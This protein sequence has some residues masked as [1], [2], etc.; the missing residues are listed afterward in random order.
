MNVSPGQPDPS[1]YIDRLADEDAFHREAAAWTL[2]EIGSPRA[3]RPLAGLLLRE[4]KSVERSG[5]VDH[6][7]VVRAVV[8]AMRRIG[9]TGGLYALVKALCVLCCAKGVDESTI[10][11]IVDSI[12]EIGGPNAMREATDRVVTDA[13]KR[14]PSAPGLKVVSGVLLSRL[15][16]C[17]D[18][19]IS[20]LR[21]LA[22]GGPAAIRPIAERVYARL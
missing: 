17:G 15:S 11:E 18:A 9:A 12:D 8:E 2:G 1:L 5:F 6:N 14:C 16:L 21:R 10:V 3:A 7:E 20:K 22:R 13:R 4:L 19:A